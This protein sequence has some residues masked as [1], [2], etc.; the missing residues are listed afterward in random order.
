MKPNFQLNIILIN[1]LRKKKS[2]KKEKKKS[3]RLTR[4]LGY[5]TG[6]T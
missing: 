2:I 5:E 6:I 1:E 4:D 3:I